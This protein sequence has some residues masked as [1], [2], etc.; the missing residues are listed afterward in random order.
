FRENVKRFPESAN[1]Y[2]SLGEAYENN[3]QFTDVQKNY[4]KA[5][6]LA[7]SKADPNLK[8]YKKN[9]KRMQEKLTHE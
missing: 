8:I 2:D 6:E 3:D 9:L 4:Q 7:T 5:V 1:V